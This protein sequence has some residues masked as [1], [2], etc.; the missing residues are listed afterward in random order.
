MPTFLVRDF[1]DPRGYR[2]VNT[3]ALPRSAPTLDLL[4]VR[5][6]GES[7]VPWGITPNGRVV[8]AK[9][10]EHTGFRGGSGQNRLR[11]YDATVSQ[12]RR[13]LAESELGVLALKHPQFTHQ[14]VEAVSLGVRRYLIKFFWKD[15][16]GMR[17]K[18]YESLGHYFFTGGEMG[19]GRISE[20]R[21]QDVGPKNVWESLL[22]V[23]E[24]GRIDQ[25]LALH[26]GVGRKILPDLKGE[27]Q[28]SDYSAWNGLV[29]EK[30][31]DDPKQRGRVDTP[32]QKAKQVQPTLTPGIAPLGSGLSNTNLTMDQS[33]K[34]GVDMFARDTGRTRN[35]SADKYYDDADLRNLLFGAGISGTTGTL[36]QAGRAFGGITSGEVLKQ[37][38]LAIVGYLV[39]G[40]M[41]SFHESLAIAHR[42]GVPYNPGAYMPSLPMTFAHSQQ[43][44]AWRDQYYDIVVLGATHWRNNPGVT[45]SHLNRNLKPP[46]TS[47]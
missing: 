43:C 41:H 17:N 8:Y 47:V 12:E 21:K 45:P 38:V 26:D 5:Q 23:L 31:F 16:D 11:Q 42:V 1:D 24:S 27:P 15:Q 35:A 4:G 20:R 18:L 14:A 9:T 30:W 37:Y 39:G 2:E 22:N 19:F 6:D 13:K 29:R 40:G 36:L 28:W 46:P 7:Y 34:R 33:R 25:Q 3:G 10:G 32:A 44:S